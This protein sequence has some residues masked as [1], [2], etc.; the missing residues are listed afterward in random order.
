[1]RSLYSYNIARNSK[2]ENK[3]QSII[4]FR[5]QLPE[6]VRPVTFLHVFKHRVALVSK[7]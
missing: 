2:K 5:L 3:K 6:K 7:I 1:M 4:S